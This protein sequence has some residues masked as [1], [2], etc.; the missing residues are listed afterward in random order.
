MRG[1]DADDLALICL[2]CCLVSCADMFAVGGPCGHALKYIYQ[3]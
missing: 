2:S 3:I 1:L